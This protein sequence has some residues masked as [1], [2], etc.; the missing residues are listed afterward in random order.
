LGEG[1]G[2]LPDVYAGDSIRAH[3]WSLPCSNCFHKDPPDIRAD[4]YVCEQ[5]GAV[6]GVRELEQPAPNW[7]F[8]GRMPVPAQTPVESLQDLKTM[9]SDVDKAR[10]EVARRIARLRTAEPPPRR[11]GGRMNDQRP[12]QK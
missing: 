5:C 11:W 6:F 10:E 9:K 7:Q 2:W 1:S 12:V 3:L 4:A 8:R